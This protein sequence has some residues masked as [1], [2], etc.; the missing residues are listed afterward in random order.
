MPGTNLQIT[1]GSALQGQPR[2]RIRFS[3]TKCRE[4]K[5][6]CNRE[7][8]CD[9]CKKRDIGETCVYIPY[10]RSKTGTD[11][12]SAAK[13]SSPQSTNHISHHPD[14]V[15]QAGN[16]GAGNPGVGNNAALLSRLRHLERLVHVLKAKS[17]NDGNHPGPNQL[18]LDEKQKSDEESSGDDGTPGSATAGPI[19]G[20]SRYV[21]FGNWE[22]ILDE[23][24]GFYSF[25][26]FPHGR[27]L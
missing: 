4:K 7:T 18:V 21:E 5:L 2:N 15:G 6:K 25:L 12:I 14:Q 23:V 8:P 3:C 26:H 13:S 16:I 22:A 1:P 9:Q 20:Q 17:S 11:T 19:F 10:A 27:G 24:G